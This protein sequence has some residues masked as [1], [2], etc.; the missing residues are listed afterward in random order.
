MDFLTNPSQLS[1]TNEQKHNNGGLLKRN[2]NDY[3]VHFLRRE[4]MGEQS[5]KTDVSA[6]I[7][8]TTAA[9]IKKKTT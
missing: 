4:V 1:T 7:T 8:A 9:A 2:I 5:E 3:V 6:A